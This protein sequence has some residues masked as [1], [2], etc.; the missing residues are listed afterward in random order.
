MAKEMI[1]VIREER[2]IKIPK[3][4]NRPKEEKKTRKTRKD[5]EVVTSKYC[6]FAKCRDNVMRVVLIFTN[7]TTIPFQRSDKAGGSDK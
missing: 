1:R 2:V 6:L 7:T 5:T 4:V 3:E